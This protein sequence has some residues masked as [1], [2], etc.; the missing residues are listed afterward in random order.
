VKE[1]TFAKQVIDCRKSLEVFTAEAQQ[2]LA[3]LLVVKKFPQDVER[4]TA[5][6]MQCHRED[7]LRLGYETRRSQLLLAAAS[8]GSDNEP[9][10]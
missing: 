3:L 4:R 8:V 10:F 7:R 2:T 6:Q 1:Q 9:I 5:L